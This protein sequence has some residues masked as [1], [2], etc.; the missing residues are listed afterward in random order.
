MYWLSCKLWF[1]VLPEG[2]SKGA[3]LQWLLQHL[4][5]DP[6]NVMAMGD[7]EN[8]VEMLQMAGVSHTAYSVVKLLIL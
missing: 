1:Q 6:V 2:A 4:G 8:D 3:G 5:V 7:G